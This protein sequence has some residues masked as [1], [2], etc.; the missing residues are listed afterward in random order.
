VSVTEIGGAESRNAALVAAV[1]NH[2]VD[3][4]LRIGRE[5]SFGKGE[6]IFE[7]VDKA[8][9]MFVVL[10]GEA[11]VEVGGWFH[12]LRPGDFFGEM[13]LLAPDRRMATV[14]AVERV[15]ALK[16]PADEFLSHLLDHPKLGV[17][18]LTTLVLRWRE[19]GAS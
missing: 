18:M 1:D 9:S 14:R 12:R 17:S 13:A 7:G 2:D 3:E 5:V 15:R 10:E 6:V 8:D 4:L 11:Q 16:V 19:V